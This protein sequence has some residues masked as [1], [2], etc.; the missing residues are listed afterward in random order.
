MTIPDFF[1]NKSKIGSRKMYRWFDKIAEIYRNLDAVAPSWC[2]TLQA[3]DKYK[4][5]FLETFPDYEKL[6][7]GKWRIQSFV[8][9]G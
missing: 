4:S 5:K 9:M 8:V 1:A 7:E 3:R 6:L 2:F